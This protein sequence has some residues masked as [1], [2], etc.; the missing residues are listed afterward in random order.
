[1]LE[2]PLRILAR[3]PRPV[4]LLVLGTLVNRIGSLIIPFLTLV[5]LRDF[6][7][8]EGEAARLMLAFGVGTLTSLVVGGFLTDRLGRRRTLLTSLLGSGTLAAA[9]G[10]APSTAVFVPLLL[11]F[12]F[13]A[14]LYRPAASAII[15]DLLPSAQRASGFAGLRMATNVGWAVGM[16]LG[17]GLADWSWRLLFVVDGITTLAYGAVVFAAI[18]ETREMGVPERVPPPPPGAS[19]TVAAPRPA[20]RP[21]EPVNPLTDPVFLQASLAGFILTLLFCSQLS[22]LPLTVTQDAGY[23]TIVYGLL[24]SLNGGLVALFEIS[25]VDRLRPLRRLRLAALGL[26]LVGIGLGA[27]GL[28]LH[29]V[30]FLMA[31]LV[32]TA[33]EILSAPQQMAFVA[34][35][36]PPEARGRYLSLYQATWS[37]AFAV[38]P[39][40]FLPLRAALGGRLFWALMPVLALPGALLLLRLSRTADRPGKL[41]GLASAP[42]SSGRLA[43]PEG[44]DP[45]DSRAPLDPSRA[46]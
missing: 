4:R 23:P 17:G 31:I 14:E 6:G 24:V 35:W 2:N 36:A 29:W 22:I 34:D 25:V 38:S 27:I 46:P 33:G 20:P 11:A 10:F 40:L 39:A 3:F 12:S 45:D 43:G 16:T 15:G 13:L 21:P 9:L 37:I 28:V 8:S 1:M 18:P 5:L 41:R 19:S 42:E 44:P 32:L 30:V 7:L 26:A